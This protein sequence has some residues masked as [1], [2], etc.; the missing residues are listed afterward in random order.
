MR[1]TTTS[2]ALHMVSSLP[3][4]QTSC[5]DCVR[6]RTLRD[7]LP[8][9]MLQALPP[10]LLLNKTFLR[11]WPCVWCMRCAGQPARLQ[12][13]S[14]TMAV[15]SMPSKLTAC[16]G[17]S[18]KVCLAVAGQHNAGQLIV[19]NSML[20]LAA[21]LCL[22]YGT[23][24]AAHESCGIPSVQHHGV[25]LSACLVVLAVTSVRQ[26]TTP[27]QA[28]LLLAVAVTGAGQSPTSQSCQTPTRD[29]SCAS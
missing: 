4:S 23:D 18:M 3:V 14:I 2:T 10:H 12:P 9:P 19:D 24:P 17:H 13:L 28:S 7:L 15:L 8:G 1:I 20:D 26:S 22:C 16:C 25:H 27:H 5:V 6:P 29:G 11:Q 21:V